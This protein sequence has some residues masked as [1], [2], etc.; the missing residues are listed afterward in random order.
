MASAG[1]LMVASSVLLS[2]G[3]ALVLGVVS[4]AIW[5]VGLL[6]GVLPAQP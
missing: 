6:K 2:A 5:G 3:P 1:R 4:L